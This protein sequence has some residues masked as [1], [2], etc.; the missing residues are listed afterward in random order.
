MCIS[1]ICQNAQQG[2]FSQKWQNTEKHSKNMQ[3]KSNLAM[4]GVMMHEIVAKIM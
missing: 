3:I 1:G 2:C 4:H